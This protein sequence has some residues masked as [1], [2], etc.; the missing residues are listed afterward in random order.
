[1]DAFDDIENALLDEQQVRRHPVRTPTVV[2][3]FYHLQALREREREEQRLAQVFELRRLQREAALIA[4]QQEAA[5]RQQQEDAVRLF[6]MLS[7]AH[8]PPMP[9][10]IPP[11][12]AAVRNADMGPSSP[13]EIDSEPDPIGEDKLKPVKGIVLD[14]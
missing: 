7:R 5:L 10:S 2:Q 6:G 11:E 3:K 9:A 13:V 4:E 8:V 14:E 1:M 12:R